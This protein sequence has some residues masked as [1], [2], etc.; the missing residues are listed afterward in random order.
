M[1]F[2]QS[3]LAVGSVGTIIQIECQAS[4]G[5]PSIVIVGL[6]NKAVDEAKERVR[7]AF[8]STG[9]EM[10]RKRITIN[11]APADLPKDS[12]SLDLPIAASIMTVNGQLP[13][14][15][16]KDCAMI[17]EIGLNGDVRAVRGIIGI[18]L[19]GE[20]L[21]IRKYVIP[22]DNVKQAM[23]IP[24]IEIFPISNICEL[25]TR[26]LV[27]LQA[28]SQPFATSNPVA[29]VCLSDIA[30]QTQAKRALEVAAAGGHNILL[31]GPP[32]TG[33]SMLA[34]AMAGIL[35]PLTHRE[36]LEVT[37][38]HS[39]ASNNYDEL[40]TDRP[41][42][43]P[44]HSS[45]HV[46]IVGGGAKTRPGE[47]TLSHKGV[48]FLDEMP[49]FNRATLEA[50]RQPLEDGLITISRIRQTIEYPADFI[51]IA[52]AN[53]CPCGFL[54]SSKP[55]ECPTGQ[56]VRYKQ[57]LSGP[58]LD[59]ID[60]HVTVDNVQHNTLLG[61]KV[62]GNDT[63][64]VRKRVA[65]ARAV[66]AKRFSSSEKINAN[67]DNPEIKAFAK[68]ADQSRDLLNQAA[69]K[70]N[71]SARSYMKVVKVSRTI[72]DLEESTYI[73]PEHI[74]EALQYR[75]TRLQQW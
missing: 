75:T 34:K 50:M 39:L 72:A 55:C 66:Q 10:P 21:G 11:L 20:R 9:I 43:A 56:I 22:A 74:S 31:S 13:S 30:G 2:I 52:T 16:S 12:T 1:S 49:E 58:I 24:N 33:K 23:L 4:N 45:S 59:R 71:L 46:S 3:I 37:H 42:R 54:G 41:F 15:L 26:P 65:R 73:R 61:S 8:A 32:G 40:V 69:A 36:M 14:Q 51:L 67:M 53:P 70:L 44:H 18:L 63:A 64:A 28:A 38:L 35:P 48:L 25:R 7:S 17:G 68:L 6:G 60:L 62:Q 19:A 27:P 47:I 57:R 5:L 29:K